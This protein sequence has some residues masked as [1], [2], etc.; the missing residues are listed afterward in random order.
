MLDAIRTIGPVCILFLFL[1]PWPAL[2]ILL[3]RVITT[4]ATPR[5][6]VLESTM[7]PIYL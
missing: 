6:A 4:E 3:P 1:I 5:D 7:G 2:I